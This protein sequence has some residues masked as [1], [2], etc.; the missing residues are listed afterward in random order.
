MP[1]EFDS[2]TIPDEPGSSNNDDN[3][4]PFKLPMSE[5]MADDVAADDKDHTDVWDP[6]HPV[7]ARNMPTMPI[8]REPGVPDPKK[9][10]AGS[11][12]LDPNPDFLPF[13]STSSKRADYTVQHEAVRIDQTAPHPAVQPQQY[14]QYQRPQQ[15]SNIPPAPPQKNALPGGGQGQNLPRRAARRRG[16]LGCSPGCLWLIVGFMAIFCGGLTLITLGLGAWGVN[17]VETL[18]NERINGVDN[19]QNFQST[20]FYD[21]KGE[22]LYEAFGEGR[23]TNVKYSEFPKYLID[24]T[25]SIEDDSFF[26]N[27]GIDVASTSRALLQYVGL[28][29]GASGGSTI[30]QQV[31]R[32]ILFDFQYRSERSIQRK[33]EEIVL[34]LALNQRKTKEEIL[35]L[36][37]NEIYYGNLSYGAEAAAQT[38]FNKHVSDLTLGEAALLAGLPQAPADLDPLSVDPTVQDAVYARWRLVLDRMVVLGKITSEQRGAALQQGLT[39]TT[40]DVSLRAPHFTVYAK[41]EL[42]HLMGDLGYSP[43]Q[44]TKGGL[45]V[46][47]TLDLDINDMAQNAA[48]EQVARLSGQNVTN[49]AVL[50]LQPET[51]EIVGMVGSVDYNNDAIDGRVNVTIALRQPGSTMKPFNYSAALEN[52]VITPGSVIWDTPTKIGIPGGDQYIPRNYDGA[53]HGPVI[54]RYA[55]ANSYNVPAVQTLRLVGVDKLLGIM[56]RF[57]TTSLGDDASKYGLSLTLGGGELSL[58]E[59]TSA[60]S[61]FPN[62]GVA[63]PSTSILCI[64]NNDDQII[65]QYENGCPRGTPT[66]TTISRASTEV[67]HQALDPRIAFI[68][69]N[70]LS[71]NRARSA[72]MGA[73][74]PLNTGNIITAVKTGTTND[75]K[76]NWTVGYSRNVAVGVWVG[77]NN[78]DPMINSSGLTG[79]APIWNSVI[80]SIYGNQN[81]LS[82]FAVNGQLVAD[83]F[84]TPPPGL[85]QREICDVRTLRDPATDCNRIVE[86]FLDG[87]AGIPDDQGN[88]YYPPAPPAPQQSTSGPQLNEISPGVYQVLAFHLA[89]EIANL[90]QFQVGPGQSP[91]PAPLYCQVPAELA[92]EAQ[93]AQPQLFIAPP[94]VP[95]DAVAAEQYARNNGLAFLPTIACSPDLLQGGGIN[96]AGS[97]G[98]AVGAITSPQPGAVLSGETKIYGTAQF[99]N[100]QGQFYKL[101][102]IGGPFPDW[103]TIGTTHT[104]NVTNGELENLYVP[105]LAN[106]DYRLRL[107][108]VDAGGGFL[109]QPYEVPFS[110]SR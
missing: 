96:G 75:V 36:Y 19:Y 22:L 88:L 74:S 62:Q 42:E 77:N 53:F 92:G 23:R 80:T 71:D 61:V 31:V 50:V 83:D 3:D 46:Y 87:P 52:G 89:P 76:D 21:R 29:Q 72:A 101:E 6:A 45:K 105:G 26:T 65:Y 20:F 86:W 109:Q 15:A 18:A 58:L 108:I 51:G 56:K 90:I 44:I 35:E 13:D 34:A 16:C 59:L 110:V 104:N 81:M 55:L 43:E 54:M 73:N 95:E 63:V 107:V 94:P 11:G 25:V 37:L 57:G 78:G 38:F 28:A 7:D 67:D 8:P 24:A 14:P 98:V 68:I 69:S 47:T 39:F 4:I 17:R 1:E 5:D 9:T 64:L 66:Q 79:A 2:K 10:L 93:G 12:G 85:V 84:Q 70:I 106:G 33:I 49:A 100:G 60:Y 97:S 103:V 82:S 41:N 91:P 40:P 32:N 48:R 99:P 102:V 30:T 27:P